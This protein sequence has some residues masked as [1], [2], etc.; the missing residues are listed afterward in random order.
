MMTLKRICLCW[1][2]QTFKRNKNEHFFFF[3]LFI[4]KI[5]IHLTV[6]FIKKKTKK[7]EYSL[8]ITYST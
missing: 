8:H 2:L 3:N 6:S 5:Y 7:N 1:V 4:Y